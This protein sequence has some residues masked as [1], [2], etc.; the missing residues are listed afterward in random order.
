[1]RR[2]SPPD[3]KLYSELSTAAL[4][5]KLDKEL[6]LFYELRAINS[7]GSS[8][9]GQ[10]RSSGWLS[11]KVAVAALVEHFGYSQSTAYRILKAGDGKF[12]DIKGAPLSGEFRGRPTIEIHGLCRVALYLNTPFLSRPIRVKAA[13]FRGRKAKRAWLYASFFKPEG[14][15]AKPI[16][17]ASLAVATGVERSQ[18]KR[19]GK[20][21][22]IRRVPNFAVQEDG[23]GI[24]AP[25]R[26][27]VDSKSNQH[28]K[29]R[30]LGNT[31]HA[32]AEKAQKGMV[33]RVNGDLKQGSFLRD[34]APL[35]RRF[36]FS[37]RSL[38]GSLQ[39]H[40]EGFL[41]VN[42]GH[43]LIRGRTEWCIA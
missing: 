22:G 34:K 33:K 6:A 13:D 4:K 36:F 7:S 16:A 1:M 35:P 19:Y 14:S 23:K 15:R 5:V 10:Q 21:A 38:V 3:I 30:R 41:L 18:Q 12:W 2:G 24:L 29:D 37:V 32:K 11:L 9:P 25:I 39:R 28:L 17:R 43:R 20:I 40:E 31:Y 42:K 26:H 8:D 27:L